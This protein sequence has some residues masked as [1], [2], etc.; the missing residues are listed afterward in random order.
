MFDPGGARLQLLSVTRE[1]E[2]GRRM[3]AVE[4]GWDQEEKAAE[5]GREENVERPTA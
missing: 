3:E 4:G 2:R 5:V 1:E